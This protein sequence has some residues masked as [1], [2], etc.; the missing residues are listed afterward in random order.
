[1]KYYYRLIELS[2]NQDILYIEGAYKLHALEFRTPL[3]GSQKCTVGD[4][5]T[6]YRSFQQTATWVIALNKT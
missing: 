3:E 2:V 1:M 6:P 5:V 4:P